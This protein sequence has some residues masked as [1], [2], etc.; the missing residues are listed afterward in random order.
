MT[1]RPIAITLWHYRC[2][3]DF[4]L[5]LR[6]LTLLYGQNSV[7]KS[8]LVRLLPLIEQAVADGAVAP[9]DPSSAAGGGARFAELEWKGKSTDQPTGFQLGLCWSDDA[10]HE[11]RWHLDTDG[12]GRPYVERLELLDRSGAVVATL[13][14]TPKG[15]RLEL[16]GHVRR[17]D[18]DFAGLRPLM[19]EG[20]FGE[21]D[22]R[23]KALR[24]QLRWLSTGR[25]SVRR[26]FDGNLPVAE[27]APDGEG[28][29]ELAASD[30][31]LLKGAAEWF[32]RE[33]VSRELRIGSQGQLSRPLVTS[34]KTA[35]FDVELADAGAGLNQVLPLLVATKLAERDGALLAVEEPESHLHPDAQRSLAEWICERVLAP[36][37]GHPVL[38]LETHSEVIVRAVQVQIAKNPSL[39]E[40]VGAYWLERYPDGSTNGSFVTFDQ[41]G[42]PRGGGWPRDAF[43]E[44]RE[45]ARELVELRFHEDVGQ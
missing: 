5:E 36:G 21:L 19:D 45:L 29:L 31:E 24:R 38:L 17:V 1:P 42:R 28:A 2:F 20:P 26:T 10:L 16:G 8:T 43:A 15:A 4:T 30:D 14:H 35:A 6:P 9:L 39:A 23:L 44:D 7:G 33:P 40:Q 18:V 12:R 34:T 11:V 32:A 3:V 22:R 37:S 25:R 41:Q 13:S 27:I